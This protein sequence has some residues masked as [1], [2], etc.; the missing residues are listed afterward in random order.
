MLS[1]QTVNLY[2]LAVNSVPI[3][4]GMLGFNGNVGSSMCHK[5]VAWR[6]FPLLGQSIHPVSIPPTECGDPAHSLFFLFNATRSSQT[7]KPL[8]FG[9]SKVCLGRD[10]FVFEAGGRQVGIFGWRT[11]WI[12]L[13]TEGKLNS[14]HFAA[15]AERKKKKFLLCK[16]EPHLMFPTAI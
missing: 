14:L 5:N 6:I 8:C 15:F 13:S 9:G 3:L 4:M 12:D 2:V 11:L 1:Q 10:P 7:A 16:Y